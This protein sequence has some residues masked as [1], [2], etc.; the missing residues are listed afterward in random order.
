MMVNS[1]RFKRIVLPSTFGLP[2]KPDVPHTIADDGN[3]GTAFL[4]GYFF[5]QQPAAQHGLHLQQIEVV[6]RD[7]LGLCTCRFPLVPDA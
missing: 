7:E 3:R 5:G 2:P 1:W 4:W 6:W